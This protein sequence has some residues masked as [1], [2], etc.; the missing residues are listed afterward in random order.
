MRFLFSSSQ[1]GIWVIGKE[2]SLWV[3]CPEFLLVTVFQI[4][5]GL[6]PT[7]GVVLGSQQEDLGSGGGLGGIHCLYPDLFNVGFT[8]RVV[9][10]CYVGAR[11]SP[12]PP[13]FH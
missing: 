1:D 10:L 9:S 4:I 12:S 3:S 7:R 6:V 5:T 11:M 8:A 2:V 13:M